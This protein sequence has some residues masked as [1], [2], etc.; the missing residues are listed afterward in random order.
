MDVG[1]EERAGERI[2]KSG[3]DECVIGTDGEAGKNEIDVLGAHA[4]GEVAQEGGVEGVGRGEGGGVAA[5]KDDGAGVVLEGSLGGG[6][7][8][9]GGEDPADDG[10]G[11]RVGD[12]VEGGKV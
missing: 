5:E 6:G 7:V 2:E 10:P 8:I 3:V 1:A 12:E 9:G 11:T 4:V